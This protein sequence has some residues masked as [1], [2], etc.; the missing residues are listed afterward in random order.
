MAG[1]V[2]RDV[3]AYVDLLTDEKIEAGLS[4]ADARRAALVEIGGVE[5]VREAVRDE[6][7]A[8][9]FRSLLQDVRYAVRLIQRAPGLATAVVVA[10]ALGIGATAATFSAVDAVLVRPLPY[11]DA[12]RLVVLLHDGTDPVSP[13]NFLAWQRSATVFE[14]MGAAEYWS[15]NL[16]TDVAPET[17]EKTVALHVTP[18][19]LPMLGVAPVLGRLPSAGSNGVGEV[20]IADALWRRRFG[21]DPRVIGRVVEL[22]AAPLVIVGVM[23]ASFHFAPFWATKAELWANFTL[24]PT[25]EG[26]SLRVFAKVKA[27]VTLDRARAEV[28]GVTAALEARQPGTN[29]HVTVTPLKDKVVGDVRATLLV[30]FGAVGCVLLIACANVAHLLLARASTREREFAVRCAI[31]ANRSRVIRQLLTESVTLSLAGG[32]AGMLFAYGGVR[33]FTT[34]GA[35]S[36]PRLH[37]MT[38]DSHVL[39]FATMLSVLTGLVFG[40]APARALA[41][42]D[43]INGLRTEDRGSTTGRASRGA[44]RLL[45]ASQVAL[46]LI[47]LVGA[48]LLLRSFVALRAV[49]PGFAPEGLTSFVASVAGS[50]ESAPGR[51]GAFYDELLE[52]LRS[53]PG[54]VAAGAI[55]HAPLVGD[56]WGAPFLVEGR[57]APPRGRAPTATYRVVSPGYFETMRIGMVAGRTFTTDDREGG[58]PVI[59][60]NARL[61][62]DAWPGES[63]VGKRMRVPFGDSADQGW[64]TVIGVSRDTVRGDL[65]DAPQPEVFLPLEQNHFYRTVANSHVAAMTFVV[66][67]TADP[68]ALVPSFRAVVH[69]LASDVAISDVFVMREVV[70]QASDGARFTVVLLGSFAGVALVLAALGVFGVISHDVSSRR[71]EIGIRLALGA[72]P[73]GIAAGVAREG[74]TAAGIGLSV[75]LAG[76]AALRGAV[77]SLLFGVAPFDRPTLSVVALG[78]MLVAGVACALPAYRA[79]RISVMRALK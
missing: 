26:E 35:T 7:T 16:R 15:P 70:D 40:L 12:D 79:S 68:T 30:L 44:R 58:D 8:A 53:A 62:Q 4:P 20:V 63:A 17:I 29:R 65:H 28:A 43:V 46:A 22:D 11:A 13:A 64:R 50:A 23:P 31:G 38:L 36:V 67:T 57:P 74:L 14:S 19:V 33:V 45:I 75:G 55:N 72:T 66:R 39:V 3:S 32:L 41:R 37:T 48:G 6:E 56:M 47:L 18:E 76:A 27:G 25:G 1:E 49:D 2:G 5:G 34:L 51:R 10:M 61:A 60:V 71:R 42:L 21:A 78:L 9:A 77:S 59:I 52:R 24:P 73:L 69:G 54:V